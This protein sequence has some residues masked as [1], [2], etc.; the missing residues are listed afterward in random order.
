MKKLMFYGLIA[1]LAGVLCSFGPGND[2]RN[3][4]SFDD[5]L[6]YVWRA[7]NCVAPYVSALTTRSMTSSKGF[8]MVDVT[9]QLPQGHCDIPARGTTVTRYD[10]QNQWAV[11]HSD[12]FVQGKILVRP[13]K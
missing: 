9:F 1:V 5:G 13:N 7:D 4:V 8:H 11:I 2:H 3:I 10:G 6:T 12:G